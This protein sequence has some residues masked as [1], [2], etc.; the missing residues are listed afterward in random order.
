MKKKVLIKSSKDDDWAICYYLARNP[1]TPVNVLIELS[2]SEDGT[3]SWYAKQ[4]R[5]NRMSLLT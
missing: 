1:N 2:N 5:K 4:N 3:I